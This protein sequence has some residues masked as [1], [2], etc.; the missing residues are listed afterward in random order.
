MLKAHG[1]GYIKGSNQTNIFSPD[2]YSDEF[3]L[4]LPVY[5]TCCWETLCAFLD[6][7]SFMVNW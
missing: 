6:S 2:S 1:V 7:V 3:L 5:K 4:I